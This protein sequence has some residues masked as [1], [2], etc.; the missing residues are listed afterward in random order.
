MRTD[1]APFNDPNVRQA[2]RLMVDRQQTADAV[3]GGNGTIGNDVFS[4]YDPVF[5]GSLPQRAHDPEQAKALLKKAGKEGL[6]VDLV[7]SD[8][9]Q[10]AVSMATV[11]AQQAKLAGVTVNLKKVN[12]GDFYGPQ[13]LKYPFAQDFSFY[14]YYLPSVAQFFVPSGPYNETHFDDPE[15]NTLFQRA[16]ATVDETARGEVAK[17]MQQIDH[18]R[19]GYIIPVFPPVIDGV[20]ANVQGIEPT[21][22]GAPLNNYDW[23]S[24]TLS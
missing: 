20:A 24:V 9:A 5:D 6:T 8:I 22:T 13:Y 1:V 18:E 4:I 12:V 15:Y 7:T 10:G 2:F 17:Q 23:R 16:L 3:F 11:F 14:Q 19:G 21:K